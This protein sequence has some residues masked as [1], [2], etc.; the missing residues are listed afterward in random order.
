MQLNDE[1]V[2]GPRG[3][4]WGRRTI[5]GNRQRGT[6]ILNN[7]LYVGRLVWNRLRYIKDP[8]TGKRVSRLNPA[9]AWISKEVPELRIIDQDAV[10]RGKGAPGRTA[11]HAQREE[12]A[13]LLGSPAPPFFALW[14][15]EVRAHAAAA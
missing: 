2:A 15:D 8:E 11:Q 9:D 12:A 6:G 5:N 7:E 1:G 14:R 3:A 13:G 4:A 10:G